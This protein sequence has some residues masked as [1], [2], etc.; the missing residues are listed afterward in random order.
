MAPRYLPQYLLGSFEQYHHRE[1][2]IPRAAAAQ[3]L[4]TQGKASQPQG[5]LL[6]PWWDLLACPP[7]GAHTRTELPALH[8]HST[9]GDEPWCQL[10]AHEFPFLSIY[11]FLYANAVLYVI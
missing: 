6:G 5:D 10:P 8:E 7:A 1:W 2:S 9:L 3:P 11:T 4:P